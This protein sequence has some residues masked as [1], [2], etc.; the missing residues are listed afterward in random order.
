[1]G[2]LVDLLTGALAGS[3]VGKSV[4]QS[5]PDPDVGGQAF[6]F[7]AVDP[8]FFSSRE[9]FVERVDQLVTDAKSVRPAEG[10]TEV[11][12]PGELEWREEQR[13]SREGIPMPEGDWNS[14]RSSL[15]TAG[16][17]SS[18]IEGFAPDA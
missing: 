10:F 3:T 6:F 18:L 9:A 11:L 16:L 1:M 8:R 7:M 2:V 13:R 15:E 5:N 4:Q 17:P 12:L 14:L